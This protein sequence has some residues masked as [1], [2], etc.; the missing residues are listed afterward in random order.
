MNREGSGSSGIKKK[1]DK[2]KKIAAAILCRR[3]VCVQEELHHEEER[4]VMWR[5]ASGPELME[6]NI[7]LT[8]PVNINLLA[9]KITNP[10]I[11]GASL[12]QLCDPRLGSGL[13]RVIR[14]RVRVSQIT[15][16]HNLLYKKG[17]YGF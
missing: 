16:I 14:V 1:G 2:T 15:L 7:I 4:H 10:E 17:Q 11:Y 8:D 9:P 5:L 3:S 12:V 13:V 6:K